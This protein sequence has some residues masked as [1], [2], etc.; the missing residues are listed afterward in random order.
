MQNSKEYTIEVHL[1]IFV[2]SLFCISHVLQVAKENGLGKS[3]FARLQTCFE[4]TVKNPV[5]FLGIQYRMHPDICL[6]P[7]RFFYNGRLRSAPTLAQQRVCPLVPYCILSLEY[8]QSD[9][10]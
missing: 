4:D 5:Q 9:S 6:W 8:K 7:S 10:G 3:L 2:L 1:S